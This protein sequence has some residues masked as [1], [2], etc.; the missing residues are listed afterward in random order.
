VFKARC[1]SGIPFRVVVWRLGSLS[2]IGKPLLTAKITITRV[3]C[4]RTD[5]GHRSILRGSLVEHTLQK[6]ELC[7]TVSKRV[8]RSQLEIIVMVIVEAM[9]RNVWEETCQLL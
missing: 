5:P 2:K 1:S 4:L 7:R 8:G 6:S 9:T 3:T